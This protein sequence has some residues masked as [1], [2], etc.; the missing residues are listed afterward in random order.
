MKGVFVILDG[1]GDLPHRAL[2]NQTPLEA[3]ETP[4][5]DFFATNG[6]LGQMYSVKKNYAPSSDEAILSIFGNDYEK[7]PRSQLEAKGEDLELSKGDLALRVNFATIDDLENKNVLDRRAG[8]TIT[9]KESKKLAKKLNK[10]NIGVDF[11]F[12]PSVQHRAILVLRGNYSENISENDQTYSN[13][14]AKEA[15]KVVDFEPTD[16]KE[17]SQKTA[18]ILNEFVEKAHKILK[19]HPVNKKR[20][21]RGLMP[22]NYLLM[23]SPG[24]RVPR[25]KKHKK[26]LSTAYMPLEAGFSELSEMKTMTRKYPK[27][28]SMDVYKNL[29]NAMKKYCKFSLKKLKK[30]YDEKDYAYIHIK[31][32]DL[33]GHDNKPH[34]K[35]EMLEYLDEKFFKKLRKMTEKDKKLQ[36]VVTG[37][38]STPCKLKRHSAHPIPVL[39]YDRKSPE[40]EKQFSEKA[41][42]RGKLGKF[43]GKELFKKAGF[44]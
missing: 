16:K 26:W 27:L 38:H 17:I 21:K 3:A 1:L 30:H 13:K 2:N 5:L 10:I 31:E 22:A 12:V 24:N 36:V 11:E 40:K 7:I 37:D 32:T 39:F 23:R 20:E 25:L 9:S 29:W 8:R 15:E 41:S 6:K 18:D 33:P 19:K 4:N 44:K 28:R 34:V 43:L 42:Q 35:K 14:D